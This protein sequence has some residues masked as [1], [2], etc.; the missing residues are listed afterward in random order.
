M[1]DQGI[2]VDE[3]VPKRDD[4]AQIRMCSAICGSAAPEYV[5]EMNDFLRELRNSDTDG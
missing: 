3:D 4:L 5:C 2:A 1:I